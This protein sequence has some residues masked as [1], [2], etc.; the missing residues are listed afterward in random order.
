MKSSLLKEVH[1]YLE[2]RGTKLEMILNL[3]TNRSQTL[4]SILLSI[5]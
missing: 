3:G 4:D 1:L 5:D 2:R